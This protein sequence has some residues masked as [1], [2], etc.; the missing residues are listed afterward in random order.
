MEF[1]IWG[2]EI[3]TMITNV[4]TCMIYVLLVSL[5]VFNATFYNISE[6]G[7]KTI[8][9]S[10]VTDKLDHKLLYTSPWSRFELTTTL[11]IALIA[12]VVVNPTTIQSRPQ[13]PLYAIWVYFVTWPIP[14]FLFKESNFG[15]KLLVMTS[16]RCAVKSLKCEVQ[17][18][19]VSYDICV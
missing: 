18:G 12:S 13:R 2:F 10:Q 9:L 14:T 17:M 16:S 8:D 15:L 7:K 5:M 1:Q 19:Q 3:Q 6:L 4:M 11:V